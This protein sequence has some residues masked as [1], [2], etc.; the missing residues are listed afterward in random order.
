[1]FRFLQSIFK[2]G[3]MKEGHPKWL[4]E[5]AIERAVDGTD[6]CLRAVPG[7]KRKLRPAV[8]LAIDHVNALVDGLPPSRPIGL[9]SRGDDPLVR[10]FFISSDEMRK[11]FGNDR[12]LGN[13]L[14]GASRVPEKITTLL[15]MEKNETVTFGAE[16]SGDVV[17]RDMPRKI[18]TFEAHR[19][20][21]PSGDEEETRRLLKRRAYDHLVSL[22]LRRITMMKTEREDLERR[23]ELL[24]SKLNILRRVGWGFEVVSPADSPDIPELEEQIGRIESQLLKSGGDDRV[25]ETYLD[26]VIGVLGRPGE[27]LWGE[28]ETMILDS[29]GIRRNQVDYNTSELTFHE[30]FNSEGRRLVVLP[31]AL[32]GREIRSICG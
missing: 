13:F 6:P 17:E 24:Q 23:R 14:R 10:A 12:N 31:I 9:G 32:D 29:M 25:L 26:I 11:V 3:Q 20:I 22:G 8:R 21:D 16:M 7:Y 2:V 15:V 27:H 18:V 4:V 28:K 19:L 30:L 1:M 5:E